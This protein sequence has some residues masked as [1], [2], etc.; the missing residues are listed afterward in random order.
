MTSNNPKQ[1]ILDFLESS[2]QAGSKLADWDIE[3]LKVDEK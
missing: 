2:N 3:T 1:Q